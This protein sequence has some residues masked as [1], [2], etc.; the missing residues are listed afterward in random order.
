MPG[1]KTYEEE[2]IEAGEVFDEEKNE[3][4]TTLLASEEDDKTTTEP[5]GRLILKRSMK[6][7]N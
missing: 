3:I 1:E 6:S 2:N 5:I 4:N 7:N